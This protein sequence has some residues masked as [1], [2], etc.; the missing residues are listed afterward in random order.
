MNKY[1]L[2]SSQLCVHLLCR[3]EFP[4]KKFDIETTYKKSSFMRKTKLINELPSYRIE[5][6]KKCLM[7]NVALQFF[8]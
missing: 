4:K 2:E 5:E 1:V 3:K 8:L 6:I 7:K